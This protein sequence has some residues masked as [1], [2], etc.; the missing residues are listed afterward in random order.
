[1]T[2]TGLYIYYIT[3]VIIIFRMYS[4]TLKKV[5]QKTVCPVTLAAASCILCLL[6]LSITSF[7]L[8]LIQSHFVSYRSMMYRLIA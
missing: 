4:F 5:C 3:H 2:V 7:T 1:M 6:C 8:C